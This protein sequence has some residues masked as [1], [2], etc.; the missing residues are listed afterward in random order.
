[1]NSIND[2]FNTNIYQNSSISI[3]QVSARGKL[4]H[5]NPQFCKLLGY[6]RAE[7]L[8]KNCT[9]ITFHED[10]VK[11]KSLVSGMIRENRDNFVFEKRLIHSGG[12]LI[13]V[14]VHYNAVR[15][16]QGAITSFCNFVI[17]IDK[18]K[19]LQQELIESNRSLRFFKATAS[20]KSRDSKSIYDHILKAILEI[21]Q[22]S[23]GFFG[24]MDQKKN[25]LILLSWSGRAL[26]RCS[27]TDK[28]ARFPVSEA[29]IW[30]DAVRRKEILIIND[31]SADNNGK[32]G[33]PK[34]HV[35][36]SKLLCVPVI[37]DKKVVAVAAVA[38]RREDYKIADGELIVDLCMNIWTI[39]EKRQTEENLKILNRKLIER[40]KDI[41]E[42]LDKVKLVLENHNDFDMIIKQI[43]NAARKVTGAAAGYVALLD[44]ENINN[45]VLILESGDMPCPADASLPMPVRRL[46]ETA[47]LEHKT[48]FYNGFPGSRS[49]KLLPEGHVRLKNVMF[50]PLT[51]EGETVGI[52]GLVNKPEDFS[53]EDREM[54][55]AFGRLAALSLMNNRD[56]KKI[57]WQQSFS[58]QLLETAQVIILM[59]DGEGRIVRF[60][61]YMEKLSGYS[62]KEVKGKDWFSAF[63][64][65]DIRDNIKKKYNESITGKNVRGNINPIK[66]KN[67]GKRII[68]WFDST[69][70][71]HDGK[72]KSIIAIGV[73]ITERQEHL[74]I[75]SDTLNEKEILIR[76][77]YHR[78]KNNMQVICGFLRL[79][80]KYTD[81]EEVRE[82]LLDAENRVMAMGLVHGMLY[83]STDLSRIRLDNFIS[84]LADLIGQSHDSIGRNIEF[85]FKMEKI[86]VLIDT[87][88][89]TGLIINELVTNCFKH[90]F[91][92]SGGKITINVNRVGENRIRILIKDNGAGLPPNFKPEK[93]RSLGLNTVINIAEQQL[94]GQIR[95]ISKKGLSWEIEFPSNLY[96][97]RV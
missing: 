93:L 79:Q 60:N 76:E 53:E 6:A 39:I 81:S 82:S 13:W 72:S 15:N 68:E 61:K 80:Q 18:E 25:E 41:T 84:E 38:N 9:D 94:D 31:F 36:I 22:S 66:T 75:I 19:K 42:L 96:K 12:Q 28:P 50:A 29:G 14:R 97:P 1:M 5:L 63:I 83:K 71:G 17:E 10:R 48:V 20:L 11:E 40:E 85:D 47:Y 69:L 88:V 3:A 58:E 24:L 95:Y 46:K 33:Y 57:K 87:A 51:L 30:G 8:G 92:E 90:A 56:A 89:P 7:L 4:L 86:N 64:P 2:D 49:Q 32:K 43:F 21:T 62:L 52:I 67:G 54:A 45:E 37:Q 77:L 73:D 35:Q 91:P 23:Y 16:D 65:D 55:Q 34:G 74:E 26:K 59:L 78:I 27:I 44:K 70:E